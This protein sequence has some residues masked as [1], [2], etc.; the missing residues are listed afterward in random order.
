MGVYSPIALAGDRFTY[1][2]GA[3]ITGGQVVYISGPTA[4]TPTSAATSAVIGVAAFDA[5]SGGL[6]TVHSEGIH[7]L[8]A[9]GA[10]T[11]GDLVI[12]AS[13]GKVTTIGSAT[14]T[15]DSQIVGKALTTATDGN[16]VN[17]RLSL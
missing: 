15:T 16:P 17:V 8:T 5:A 12:A 13:G 14:A 11:A 4:V 2:A 6:V 3:A 10:I 9:S 1:T 7:P